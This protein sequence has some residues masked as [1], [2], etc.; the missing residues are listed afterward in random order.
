MRF[1][2]CLRKLHTNK[3]TLAYTGDNFSNPTRTKSSKTFT[4]IYHVFS[5]S[6]L[7]TQVADAG[8]EDVGRVEERPEADDDSSYGRGMQA[9]V[10]K[11]AEL[12]VSV[13]LRHVVRQRDLPVICFHLR[14]AHQAR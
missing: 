3:H 5:N 12:A 13:R 8:S 14:T 6:Y 10:W 4:H 9:R 2:P 7:L 11:V 1:G